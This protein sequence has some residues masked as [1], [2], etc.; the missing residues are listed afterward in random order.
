MSVEQIQIQTQLQKQ[1]SE[2]DNLQLRANHEQKIQNQEKK[3]QQIRSSTTSKNN[4]VSL[5]IFLLN[6]VAP[7]Q[8]SCISAAYK[9]CLQR[10]TYLHVRSKDL[11]CL[12]NLSFIKEFSRH[13]CY[14][15]GLITWQEYNII[16]PLSKNYMW[17]DF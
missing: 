2:F 7:G 5:K 10:V 15:K 9:K 14:N 8:H 6:L 16:P 12:A 17:A 4:S 11:T 1:D 13:S 3:L